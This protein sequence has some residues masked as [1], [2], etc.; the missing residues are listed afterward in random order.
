MTPTAKR[1]VALLEAQGEM[2]VVDMAAH[3]GLA[4][5]AVY[6]GVRTARHAGEV[7]ITGWV[8]RR[9]EDWKTRARSTVAVYGL[10]PGKDAPKPPPT[11]KPPPKVRKVKKEAAPP[12]VPRD[13][14]APTRKVL[15]AARSYLA[16]HPAS[17]FASMLGQ[18]G[19]V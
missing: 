10:G 3:L 6:N 19:A 17:P 7:H 16:D 4:R 14:D 11:P 9:S 5:A 8:T 12:P 15:D 2:S 13:N 1:I 18:M